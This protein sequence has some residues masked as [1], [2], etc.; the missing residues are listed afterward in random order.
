MIG[1][2]PHYQAANTEDGS[3]NGADCDQCDPNQN[4]VNTVEPQLPSDH[5]V[6][7][8]GVVSYGGIRRKKDRDELRCIKA[9]PLA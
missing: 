9:L 8:T 4:T 2:V 3:A 6:Y 7:S 1:M 5:S